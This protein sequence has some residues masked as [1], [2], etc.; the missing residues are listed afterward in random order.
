[1]AGMV[2]YDSKLSAEGRI[3]IPAEVRRRLGVAAGDRLAFL[4]DDQGVRLV[5]P[6]SLAEQLWVNNRGSD[7]GEAAEDLRTLRD[8]DQHAL[9][10]RWERIEAEAL[11][12]TRTDDLVLAELLSGLGLT[13]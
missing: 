8:E 10:A 4:V 1:M 7:T 3:V 11:A 9:E 6:R 2:E 12:D 13:S 5:T